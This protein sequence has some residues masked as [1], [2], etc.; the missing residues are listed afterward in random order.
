MIWGEVTWCLVGKSK[1][2][3][4]DGGRHQAVTAMLDKMSAVPKG[5][6]IK[7]IGAQVA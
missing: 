2:T 1:A 7:A 6:S 4:A 3:G 5:R